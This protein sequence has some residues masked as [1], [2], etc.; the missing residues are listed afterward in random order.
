MTNRTLRVRGGSVLYC[1]PRLRR[2][3]S[4]P[5]GVPRVP[6]S[7]LAA[8]HSY[9]FAGGGGISKKEWAAKAR[10]GFHSSKQNIPNWYIPQPTI[11]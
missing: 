1:T 10:G 3:E 6:P 4:R 8:P 7:R 2:N 9:F 11:S 5:R